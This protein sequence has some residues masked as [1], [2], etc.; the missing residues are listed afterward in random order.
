MFQNLLID[1]HRDNE[2]ENI[3]HNRESAVPDVD[4][5]IVQAVQERGGHDSHKH[6]EGVSFPLP[7]CCSEHNQ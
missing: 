1:N 5:K 6:G 7:A 3:D 4:N 2:T